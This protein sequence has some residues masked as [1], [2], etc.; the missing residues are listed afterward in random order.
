MC[1]PRSEA[2]LSLREDKGRSNP[3]E[4]R[5]VCGYQ[6]DMSST[7]EEIMRACEALPADKQSALADFA[8][9]LLARQDDA[10]WERRL[11]SLQARPRLDAFLHDSAAEGDEP[12]DPN[13]L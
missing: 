9:F 4:F 11:A 12:L 3:L 8:R 1:A 6:F 10:E 2:V 7:T 13:R 5:S